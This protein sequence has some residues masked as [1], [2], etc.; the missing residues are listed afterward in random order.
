VLVVGARAIATRQVGV[1]LDYACM[2][3]GFTSK[4]FA[5][6]RGL[7]HASDPFRDGAA[8]ERA[9]DE[10][11]YA[12]HRSAREAVALVRCPRCGGR[13]DDAW[14]WLRIKAALALFGVTALT[15]AFGVLF[16][17]DGSSVGA[18]VMAASTPILLGIVYHRFRWR[19][20]TAEARVFFD[21]PRLERRRRLEPTA[22]AWFGSL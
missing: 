7:G 8:D 15:T 11:F 13:D 16:V 10:A 14:W 20:K 19:T 21:P 2:H 5:I 3:C 9:T 4:V 12:A 6:G 22:G 1:P 18:W 17:L